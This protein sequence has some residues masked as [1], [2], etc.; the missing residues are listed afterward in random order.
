MSKKKPQNPFDRF[1]STVMSKDKFGTYEQTTIKFTSKNKKNDIDKNEVENIVKAL[2]DVSKK[3]NHSVRTVVRG[4]NLQR[5][6]TL[7]SLDGDLLIEEFEE[8]YKQNP[9][10]NDTQKFEKFSEIQI[11]LLVN[12][13]KAPEI[14][15]NIFKKN[16]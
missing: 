9:T 1:T 5:L 13:K 8:Y 11:T 16:K 6:F 7:K 10:V 15:K 12:K 14:N 4:M 3:S 2:E